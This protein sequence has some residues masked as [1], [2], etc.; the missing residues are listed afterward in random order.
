MSALSNGQDNALDNSAETSSTTSGPIAYDL[1]DGTWYCYDPD[2]ILLGSAGPHDPGTWEA[3]ISIANGIHS[4]PVA[5]DAGSSMGTVTSDAVVFYR[6]AKDPEGNDLTWSD[7]KQV[8]QIACIR[9]NNSTALNNTGP[10]FVVGA[11][12]EGQGTNTPTWG[13]VGVKW[14]NATSPRVN[15]VYGGDDVLPGTNGQIADILD[16][17]QI[18]GWDK[19]LTAGEVRT[20]ITNASSAEDDSGKIGIWLSASRNNGSSSTASSSGDLWEFIAV[21]TNVNSTSQTV[22]FQ[23]TRQFISEGAISS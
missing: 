11:I 1:T 12:L 2:T 19:D 5:G 7:T 4:I 13:G 16:L 6:K 20:S 21:E 22:Q 10:G 9:L 15:T 3:A 17:H 8:K 23:G 18:I 14:T